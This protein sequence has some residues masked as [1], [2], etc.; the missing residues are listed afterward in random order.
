MRV[1]LVRNEIMGS[2][3]YSSK[4]NAEWEFLSMLRDEGRKAADEFLQ[5]N[6]EG[7]G[8]RSTFD[9]DVLLRSGVT[10]GAFRH[11]GRPRL[12]DRLR[13]SGLERAALGA[14]LGADRR[15]VRA[16]AAACAL[17]ADLHG[18][19]GAIPSA[20]LS[21]LSARRLVRKADGRFRIGAGDRARHDRKARERA[22]GAGGRA[23]RRHRHLW[24]RQCVRRPSS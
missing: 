9:L 14:G 17:D 3:G 23:G 15:D 13:L 4:L 20:V 24:R 19:R 6:G 2:L 22:R 21:D 8:V 12:S 10:Y 7:I 11:P 16:R 1:H 5:A 18:K